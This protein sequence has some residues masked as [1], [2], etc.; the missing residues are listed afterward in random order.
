MEVLD[1]ASRSYGAP[2][3]P[4]VIVLHGLLG[5]GSNL[6]SLAKAL[7]DSYQVFLLDLAVEGE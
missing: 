5:D 6:V 3:L 4:V 2:D 7:E 1:L